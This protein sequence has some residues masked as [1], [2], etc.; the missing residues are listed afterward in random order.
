[1]LNHPALIPIALGL[2]SLT[3]Q[4]QHATTIV[5]TGNDAATLVVRNDGPAT[6]SGAKL[7]A[8]SRS[9]DG[10]VFGP[11]TAGDLSFAHWGGADHYSFTE[12]SM[13]LAPG[14]S[15]MFGLNLDGIFLGDTTFSQSVYTPWAYAGA[16][17]LM[18]WSDGFTAF[19]PMSRGMDGGVFSYTDIPPAVP[20]PGS[21][22]L[23]LAGVGAVSYTHLTLPT[24][25]EV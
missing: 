15:E 6:V 14:E 13:S 3:A 12:L 24:N 17:A 2:A 8:G 11:G 10:A 19:I 7:M 21:L 9:R 5:I 16:S 25:R 20:E 22:A 18:S 1:M 4:A 23:M